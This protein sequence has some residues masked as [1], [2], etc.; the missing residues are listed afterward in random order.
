[1]VAR[2]GWQRKPVAQERSF[3]CHTPPFNH[4]ETRLTHVGVD[5]T[6]HRSSIV[7]RPPKVG[8]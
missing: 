1:M 8:A 6:T 3:P 4:P 2:M 5:G 7:D